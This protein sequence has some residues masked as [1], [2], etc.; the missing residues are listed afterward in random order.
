M[1]IF[2]DGR[3]LALGITAGTATRH[4]GTGRDKENVKK[5]FDSLNID[6]QKILGINQTH[7]TDIVQII[8]EKDLEEY[9]KNQT[10][11]ADAWLLGKK[12]QGVL[13]LT[14]DCAPVFVWDDKG[15][16]VGLAHCGWRGVAAGLPAKIAREVKKRAGAGAN[17]QAFIGPHIKACCFEVRQDVAQKFPPQARVER[18]GKIYIN[19]TEAVVMQ[20]TGE[21]VKEKEINRQNP[22]QCTMC[23][24]EN[25]FSYRRDKTRDVLMSFAYK[26]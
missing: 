5:L 17:L 25:F 4:F 3:L 8:T 26:I 9:Q 6:H 12:E 7:G 14:A 15:R 16:Y 19:L 13:I 20:L 22:F 10:H 11:N 1:K 18:G 21:G 23:N 24:K 2:A